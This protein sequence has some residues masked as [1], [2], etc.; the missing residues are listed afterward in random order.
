[1]SAEENIAN[2]M[3]NLDKMHSEGQI[4]IHGINDDSIAGE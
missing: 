2:H 3:K 1:M 4:Y